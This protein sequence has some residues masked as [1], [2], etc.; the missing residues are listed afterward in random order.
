MRTGRVAVRVVGGRPDARGAVG[1]EPGIEVHRLHAQRVDQLQRAGIRIDPKLVLLQV[2]E[3]ARL[4]KRI[5]TKHAD[6][7]LVQVGAAHVDRNRQR[8][9]REHAVHGLHFREDPRERSLDA[10]EIAD[11]EVR[12][13]A[14]ARHAFHQLDLVRVAR[15]AG[16]GAGGAPG[17]DVYGVG[18]D[19]AI[20]AGADLDAVIEHEFRPDVGVAAA[21]LQRHEVRV[22]GAEADVG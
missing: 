14:H 10:A 17:A 9:R 19:M 1:D 13:L 8:G 22:V 18:R 5:R 15:G 6:V 21:V 12:P 3:P 7:H 20:G 2:A 11:R 4:R 16:V